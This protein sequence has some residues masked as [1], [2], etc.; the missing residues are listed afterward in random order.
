[1]DGLLRPISNSQCLQKNRVDG[2]SLVNENMICGYSPQNQQLGTCQGDSGGPYVC[3]NAAK[4]FVSLSINYLDVKKA[5]LKTLD[6]KLLGVKNEVK[7]KT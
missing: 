7:T 4:R 2:R 5:F 3:L 6:I 1:M